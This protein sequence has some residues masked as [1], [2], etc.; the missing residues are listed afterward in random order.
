M[1]YFDR[2]DVHDDHIKLQRNKYRRT[3]TT[4]Q[5]VTAATIIVEE[6]QLVVISILYSRG[7]LSALSG[8][9]G[10]M[11]TSHMK[12]CEGSHRASFVPKLT[13]FRMATTLCVC[14]GAV[15][16]FVQN[17]SHIVFAI[18]N[19]ESRWVVEDGA[20]SVYLTPVSRGLPLSSWLI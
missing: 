19:Y 16:I 13:R 12:G 5:A 8:L 7:P 3:S 18:V 1:I 17:E 14:C 2:F 15:L 11:S 4:P 20:P 10:G 9:L 6:V